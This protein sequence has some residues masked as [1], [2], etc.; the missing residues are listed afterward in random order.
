MNPRYAIAGFIGVLACLPGL[1]QPDEAKPTQWFMRQKLT[2]AQ[3]ILEGVT[4]EK[5]DLV[6]TN[7]APLRDM[8]MT[9]A[10]K[11]LGNPDYLQRITN[12]QMSV[13]ALSA[14]A[15]QANVERTAKAY[16][17]MT[18]SC[19]ECHRYFRREQFTKHGA[20]GPLK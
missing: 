12:F 9:N 3:G 20:P 6:L 4:L 16:T 8:S 13:D 7:A 1:A 2:Y 18:E 19:I 17:K 5:F 11:R 15:K 10:F 14:A